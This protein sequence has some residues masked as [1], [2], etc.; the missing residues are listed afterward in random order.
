MREVGQSRAE[1]PD[2]RRLTDVAAGRVI[3]SRPDQR[4]SWSGNHMHVPCNDEMACPQDEIAAGSGVSVYT[5][6][7]ATTPSAAPLSAAAQSEESF[8]VLPFV[9]RIAFASACLRVFLARLS[10]FRAFSAGLVAA[11]S[12]RFS[13]WESFAVTLAG[14]V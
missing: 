6:S 14:M 7:P 8:A 11:W 10:S 2:L 3:G 5:P 12:M 4:Q 13:A 9:A 1:V